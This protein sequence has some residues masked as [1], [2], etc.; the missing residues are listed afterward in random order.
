MPALFRTM[1]AAPLAAPTGDRNLVIRRVYP[2]AMLHT[3]GGRVIDVTKAPYNVRNDGTDAAGTTAGIKAA[4]NFIVDQLRTNPRNTPSTNYILYFPAGTYLVN[5]TLGWD[6]EY[7]S[8]NS[9]TPDEMD[10]HQ[11]IRF[12]GEDRSNTTIKLANN[13]SGFG[14]GATYGVMPFKPVVTFLKSSATATGGPFNNLETKS[15]I[16]G[17][18]IDT[19]AGNPGAVGVNF[20][21]ANANE[22]C[23]LTVKSSDPGGV[24]KAGIF[25][26]GSA[27]TWV[28]DVTVE[29]FDAGIDSDWIGETHNTLEY[30]T[31]RSQLVAGVRA[32]NSTYAI[33]KLRSENAVPAIDCV[34]QGSFLAIVESSLDNGA[35]VQPAIRFHNNGACF[36]RDIT[37]NGYGAAI[38]RGTTTVVSG[39]DVGEYRSTLMS[40]HGAGSASMPLPA[41]DVPIVAWPAAD[42]WAVVEDNSNAAAQAA[43]NS[44]LPGV[45]FKGHT[46][47]IGTVTVPASVRR[48]NFAYAKVSGTFTLGESSADPVLFEDG[49][50]FI[51]LQNGKSRT[52]VITHTGSAQYRNATPQATD[53][54]FLNCTSSMQNGEGKAFVLRTMKVFGRVV[55]NEPKNLPGEYACFTFENGAQVWILGGKTESNS[56]GI[57]AV[58]GVRLEVIGFYFNQT[59]FAGAMGAEPRATSVCIRVVDS[60]VSFSG[61]T[62]GHNNP[63]YHDQIRAIKAGTTINIPYA[64]CPKRSGRAYNCFLPLYVEQA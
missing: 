52:V 23:D 41:E 55:N 54:V 6:G 10:N 49:Y 34:G 58:N 21:G 17:F 60:Q 59:V 22:I 2:A 28:H 18:T 13:A 30:V 3:N 57:S 26:C 7:T 11:Y 61:Y 9:D 27:L 48:I 47:S 37:T 20:V 38:K 39:P 29:G 16:R 42:Q 35:A 56:H 19:G 64:A 32:G 12:I 33:R 36:A 4:Y 51:V 5:D 8:T 43:L 31:V 50:G 1:V 24:G 63:G 53:K 45:M 62:D 44:G 46:F 25:L 15:C 14:A 40:A